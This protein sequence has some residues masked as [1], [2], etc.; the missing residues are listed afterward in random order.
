MI[1][2]LIEDAQPKLFADTHGK[3]TRY[4]LPLIT[5]SG[6]IKLASDADDLLAVLDYHLRAFLPHQNKIDR[7]FRLY[8][9]QDTY[10]LGTMEK[11]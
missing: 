2:R 9:G 3:E 7:I 11:K 5:D 1:N 8:R 4:E 10:P 6:C